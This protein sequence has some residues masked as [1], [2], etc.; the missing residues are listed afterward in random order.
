MTSPARSRVVD[1]LARAAAAFP[2]LGPQTL[3]TTKLTPADARL[4]LAIHRTTLQRWVTLR[5]L[6]ERHTRGKQLGR[7]QPSL[8]AVLLTAT[9]QLLFFDK[10]ADHAVVSESVDMAKALVR[11]DA[12][13]LVNAVLRRVIADRQGIE[14]EPWQPAADL[15]P[16]PA[17]RLRFNSPVF[18]PLDELDRY[19]AFATSHPRKLVQRWLTTFGADATAAICHHNTLNPPTLLLQAGSCPQDPDSAES[20]PEST[21]WT[22]THDELVAHLAAHPG[23]RVQDP[24]AAL[25]VCST[26]GLDPKLIVDACAG[27]GTKTRQLATLHPGAT[28][29][30]S[31]IDATR[32]ADL[33]KGFA[34]QPNVRVTPYPE[35]PMQGVDLLL[36]DVPCSN[37][38]VLA[39]RPEARYR[40]SPQSLA[41]VSQLQR[42]I[43][44]KLVP[45]VAPGG[46]LLYATCS[47]EHEENRAAINRVLRERPGTL[48]HDRLVLPSRVGEPYHDGS[49]HALVRFE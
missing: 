24:A 27:R 26:R 23:D 19:L 25:P 18:P 22:G 32:F 39:R 11:K 12:G 10:A 16:H 38:A 6:V 13:S 42:D 48:V 35:L 9:A 33:R 49:Y 5:F 15:A 17:G 43:L 1:A 20:L 41:S 30:A 21:P 44:A 47:L 40:L 37:S 28:I 7:M 36:L 3:E 29:I 2:D 34:G 45:G 8:Q 46:H 14:P 31:D 4:A